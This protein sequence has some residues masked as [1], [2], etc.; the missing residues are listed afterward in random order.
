MT[1]IPIDLTKNPEVAALVADKSPGDWILLKAS[2]KSKDDQTLQ[3]RLEECDDCEKPESDEDEENGDEE[4]PPPE[5][6]APEKPGK[7]LAEK[8]MSGPG[9]MGY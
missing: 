2:I 1:V 4:T 9:E 7:A 5:P 8:L 6:P 3:V